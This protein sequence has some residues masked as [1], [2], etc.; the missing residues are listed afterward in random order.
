MV[1][2]FVT[3]FECQDKR[4]LPLAPCADGNAGLVQS[5]RADRLGGIVLG[6]LIATEAPAGSGISPE[7][8]SPKFMT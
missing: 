2:L 8:K 5:A 3:R 1:I 4:L 6:L 7:Q